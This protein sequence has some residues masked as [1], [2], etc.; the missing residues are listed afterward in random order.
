MTKDI[1]RA[2]AR[3][4]GRRISI[5]HKTLTQSGLS[6]LSDEGQIFIL[7]SE[8]GEVFARVDISSLFES[9]MS[10][11]NPQAQATLDG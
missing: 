5:L 7:D 2:M 4:V 1:K 9:P 11:P 3:M 6:A 10:P 8:T